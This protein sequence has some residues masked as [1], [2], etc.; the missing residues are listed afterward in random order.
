MAHIKRI[1]FNTVQ[2]Q[3]GCTCDRCGQW[4]K[5]VW[6]V[7]FVED[8]TMHYGIDCFEKLL[9][10]GNLTDYGKKLMKKALKGMKRTYAAMEKAADLKEEDDIWWQAQQRD[11]LSAWNGESYE[12][13]KQW[14]LS[15]FYPYHIERY[16]KEIEKLKK[17]DFA[18]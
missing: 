6:T 9:K 1:Y 16:Q 3:E 5:N 2:V 10:S 13:Y 18:I 4:I 8:L 12:S 15:S 14:L 11:K 17:A 7:E